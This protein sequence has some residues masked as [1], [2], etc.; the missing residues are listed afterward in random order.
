MKLS[1]IV[2]GFG[3]GVVL[4]GAHLPVPAFILCLVA[5][6]TMAQAAVNNLKGLDHE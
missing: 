3:L 2:L 6:G 5:G 4:V 1:A